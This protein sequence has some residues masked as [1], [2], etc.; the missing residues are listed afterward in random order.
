VQ[1]KNEACRRAL[2]LACIVFPNFLFWPE[3]LLAVWRVGWLSSFRGPV[4]RYLLAVFCIVGWIALAAALADHRHVVRHAHSKIS[5]GELTA[6][7]ERAWDACVHE[8]LFQRNRP[9]GDYAR[10]C[11]RSPLCHRPW[12]KA[13]FC[14]L[15][16]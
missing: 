8:Y 3:L 2:V 5:R 4:K 12:C 9:F 1:G 10:A 11:M 14:L 16:F 15:K 6:M 13:G 7:C